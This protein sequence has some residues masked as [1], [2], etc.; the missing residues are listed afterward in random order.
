LFG[1]TAAPTLS[2]L[3][4][5][6]IGIIGIALILSLSTGFQ[7]QIDQF[8]TDALA[9]FPVY[10]SPAAQQLEMEDMMDKRSSASSSNVLM[11]SFWKNTPTP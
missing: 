5:L 10:I 2:L 8:Q 3:I 11:L 9:E 7:V 4:C 6:G 1:E